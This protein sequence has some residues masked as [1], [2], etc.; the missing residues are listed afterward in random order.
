MEVVLELTT[1]LAVIDLEIVV[2]HGPAE[3][4]AGVL[5]RVVLEGDRAIGE[6]PSNSSNSRENTCAKKRKRHFSESA[7][8]MSTPMVGKGSV[9]VAVCATT[10]FASRMPIKAG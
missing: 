10:P 9:P 6:V 5:E 3:T 4:E 8:Q 1:Q 7:V 2:V